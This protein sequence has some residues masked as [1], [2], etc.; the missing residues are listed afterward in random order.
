MWAKPATEAGT[1]S[2]RCPTQGL[3]GSGHRQKLR[4][5]PRVAEGCP[6]QRCGWEP[7]RQHHG[8]AWPPWAAPKC[9]RGLG[10][11]QLHGRSNMAAERT[12]V[13]RSM[14]SLGKRQPP[15]H[16][17][18]REWQVGSCCS[19]PILCQLPQCPQLPCSHYPGDRES[20]KWPLQ[21]T[22]GLVS[23]AS[24]LLKGRD[25]DTLT[26][27]TLLLERA[28][29]SY[30]ICPGDLVALSSHWDLHGAS[31]CGTRTGPPADPGSCFIFSEILLCL[32]RWCAFCCCS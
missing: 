21:L 6:G 10:R 30:S 32:N 13:L 26:S 16:G 28:S 24:C 8:R 7:G 9:L 27:A 19:I 22:L 14:A 3:G 20:L 4:A 12:L 31:G 29:R 2:E 15:G 17:R 18:P 5:A 1:R 23:L 11:C 25:Q